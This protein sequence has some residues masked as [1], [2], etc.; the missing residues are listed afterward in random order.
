MS[1]FVI[2]SL[3][4]GTYNAYRKTSSY[5]NGRLVLGAETAF[6]V[7]GSLQPLKADEVLLLPE[8]LRTRTQ[9]KFYTTDDLRTADEPNGIEPDQLEIS[10]KRYSVYYD[11][12]HLVATL[13][14]RV[15]LIEVNVT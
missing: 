10:G 1:L 13:H 7:T 2:P 9:Y 5:V 4:S 14:R 15:F 8:G 12:N 6:S 11:K 3:F